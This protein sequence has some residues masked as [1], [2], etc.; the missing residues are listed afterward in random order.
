MLPDF[1][2]RPGVRYIAPVSSPVESGVRKEGAVELSVKR[3]PGTQERYDAVRRRPTW[4][5]DGSQEETRTVLDANGKPLESVTE[6]VNADGTHRG[7]LGSTQYGY[8]AHGRLTG[9]YKRKGTLGF[10][11]THDS[12]S[13]S[14]LTEVSYP[15]DDPTNDYDYTQTNTHTDQNGKTTVHTDTPNM[16]KARV[17]TGGL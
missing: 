16:R 1:K 4:D 17:G 15:G 9:V 6:V 5:P 13:Q 7:T 8:D 10:Y 14:E 2:P 12:S 11:S 3:R